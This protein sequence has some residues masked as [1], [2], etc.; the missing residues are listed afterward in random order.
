MLLG[1]VSRRERWGLT[2]RG[3]ALLAAS[4]VVAGLIAILG[5]HPFLAVTDRTTTDL[6][7]V[8]GW[9]DDYAVRAASAE[10]RTGGYLDAIATGG[11]VH[12]IGTYINVYSTAA[13]ITAQRLKREGLPAEHVHMAP[14]R[15][16][17]RDRTYASAIA[18]RDWMKAHQFSTIKL[19]VL[20][21][22]VHARRTRLLF[23]QA[24]GPAVTV[25]VI[26]IPNPDYDPKRWWTCSEGVRDVLSEGI[27]YVYARFFFF[28]AAHLTD[29][30]AV[31]SDSKT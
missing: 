20:T 26:A 4:I 28:P 3:W 12:G 1:L 2:L 27:S 9:I 24:F 23:Q 16:V 29:A 10:F 19:N 14:A 7:V 8:E 21:E 25:G 17:V 11:P 13:S 31:D 6:L 22:D 18:L 5:V 30:P 15:I